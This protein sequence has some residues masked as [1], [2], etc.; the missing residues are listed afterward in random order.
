[1]DSQI[2][3]QKSNELNVTVLHLDKNSL[4]LPSQTQHNK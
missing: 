1:M 3:E 4:L 2:N